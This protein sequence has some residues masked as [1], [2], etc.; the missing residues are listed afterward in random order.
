MKKLA[1]PICLALA[2]PTVANAQGSIEKLYE[3]FR[4]KTAKAEN[5]VYY[6]SSH[7]DLSVSGDLKGFWLSHKEFNFGCENPNPGKVRLSCSGELSIISPCPLV[8][9]TYTVKLF[10]NQ[11]DKYK[12]PTYSGVFRAEKVASRELR[13]IP[14][15]SLH[16]W[17]SHFSRKKYQLHFVY[18]VDKHPRWLH[19]KRMPGIVA[20][21]NGRDFAT[22]THAL[23]ASFTHNL[24]DFRWHCQNR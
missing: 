9:N 14:R 15:A 12:G 8:S 2:L 7:I 1:L 10:L 20:F 17:V 24:D 21:S 22:I 11:P 19:Q 18:S 5:T 6:Q 4:W 23:G 13:L 3:A 16:R